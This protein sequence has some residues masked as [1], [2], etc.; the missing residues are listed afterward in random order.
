MGC[1]AIDFVP[2]GCVL[3]CLRTYIH[4]RR[5]SQPDLQKPL[6]GGYLGCCLSAKGW[7]L[8][9]HV[10]T[11]ICGGQSQWRLEAGSTRSCCF[12]CGQ[13]DVG[14]GYMSR[15]LAKLK[16]IF[17]GKTLHSKTP[18]SLNSPRLDKAK[19]QNLPGSGLASLLKPVSRASHVPRSIPKRK[20]R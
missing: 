1:G 10:Y 11:S 7:S 17:S 4:S 19:S 16:V 6:F 2:R 3:S 8:H 5:S 20:S 13:I 14:V 12:S 15:A 18:E 9:V